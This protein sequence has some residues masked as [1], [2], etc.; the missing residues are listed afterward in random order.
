M[1]SSSQCSTSSASSSSCSS[2]QSNEIEVETTTNVDAMLSTIC[3]V[4]EAVDLLCESLDN[5]PDVSK[6]PKLESLLLRALHTVQQNLQPK[7]TDALQTQ[8]R[9]I[10]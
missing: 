7:I 3:E 1:N 10:H 8:K 6:L 4:M 9:K 2:T 5:D